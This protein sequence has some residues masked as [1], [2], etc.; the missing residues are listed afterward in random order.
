M[1]LPPGADAHIQMDKFSIFSEE[2]FFFSDEIRDGQ[3]KAQPTEE[4]LEFIRDFDHGIPVQPFQAELVWC[5]DER[6]EDE[7]ETK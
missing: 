4:A 2:S 1:E 7:N 3:Y 5:Q 6:K